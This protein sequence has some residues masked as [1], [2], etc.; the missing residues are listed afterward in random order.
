MRPVLYAQVSWQ[1]TFGWVSAFANFVAGRR[2]LGVLLLWK[3]TFSPKSGHPIPLAGALFVLCLAGQLFAENQTL[4]LTGAG[5][6]TGVYALASR[7]GRLP[8]LAGM[9]GC[10]LGALLM[11]GNPLYGQLATSGTA[12]EGVRSL[13]FEPG[14]GLAS[15]AATVVERLFTVV[16][17]GLFEYYPGVCLL[18]SVGCL[19]RLHRGGARWYWQ[20]LVGLWSAIYCAQCWVVMEQLRQLDSWQCPWQPVRVAGAVIQLILLLAVVVWD[21][22]ERRNA[23]LLLLLAAVGMLAPFVVVKD[24]GA[25][26]RFSLG[27]RPCWCWGCLWGKGW[28]PNDGFRALPCSLWHSAWDSTSGLTG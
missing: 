25:P 11:F 12:V 21:G 6:V 4:A 18:A 23:R 20:A 24:Y 2:V 10:L 19:W 7:R 28:R 5:V 22:G 15:I 14:Q 9:A 16:L 17:P 26:V 13:V 3:K 27:R 8:A 1:Q